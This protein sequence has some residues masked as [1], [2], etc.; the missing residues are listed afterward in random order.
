MSMTIRC[1]QQILMRVLA[2]GAPFVVL[3]GWDGVKEVEPTCGAEGQCCHSDSS[4]TNNNNL[5]YSLISLQ[6]SYLF[7]IA[8]CKF[9]IQC[10]L[11]VFIPLDF[12]HIV[13]C[14]IQP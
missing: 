1:R 4:G 6:L 5:Q 8:E 13:L 11:K 10:I 12:F 3:K 2:I 14:Y 9:Q 7:A